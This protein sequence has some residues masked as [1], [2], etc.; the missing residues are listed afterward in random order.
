MT[1][2]P[3]MDFIA[4]NLEFL[5]YITQLIKISLSAGLFFTNYLKTA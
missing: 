4:E 1:I 2:F 3:M 5:S